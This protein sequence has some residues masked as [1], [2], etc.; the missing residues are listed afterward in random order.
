MLI[1]IPVLEMMR[2]HTQRDSL[3]RIKNSVFKTRM[4]F[5]LKQKRFDPFALPDS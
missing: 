5:V 4:D 2:T 3:M 1:R